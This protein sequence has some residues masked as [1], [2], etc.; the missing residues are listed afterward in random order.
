M[1][2]TVDKD[3]L[4]FRQDR[5]YYDQLETAQ[6]TQLDVYGSSVQP[7]NARFSYIFTA[8]GTYTLPRDIVLTHL[9]LNVEGSETAPPDRDLEITAEINSDVIATCSFHIEPPSTSVNNISIPIPNWN[10]KQGETIGSTFVINV[11]S[12]GARVIFIGIAI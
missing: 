10:L 2:L 7:I 6:N 4:V 3:S 8:S 5:Q 12:Y 1:G 9:I 11:G